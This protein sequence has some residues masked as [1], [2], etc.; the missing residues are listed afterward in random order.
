MRFGIG[1]S[2]ER[3]EDKRFLTGTGRYSDDINLAHQSHAAIVHSPHSHARIVSI[4]S[5]QALDAPGVIAVFT[6]ADISDAE[7]GDLPTIMQT[8]RADGTPLSAP[9]RAMLVKDTVRFAGDYVAMV[10]AQT[11]AQAKDAADLV[12]VEYEVLPAVTAT[13]AA[14]ADDAPLVWPANPNNISFERRLGNFDAVRSALET[15]AHVTRIDLPVSR[16]AQ[17]PMEPRCALGIYDRGEDRYTLYTGVQNPHDMR[18]EI[19]HEVLHIPET[20]LRVVSPDMGGGF[21]MRSTVFP[22]MALVLW[23]AR[24]LGRPVKW[25][26]DRSAAFLVDDQARDAMIRVELGLNAAAE[27]LAIRVRKTANVGAYL[28]WY[29]GYPA[30]GNLGSLAGPYRTPVICAHV[31]GVYTHTTPVAPYRGAGRPE[32]AL[33]IEQAVDQAARELGIDRVEI[34]R[35]N[36]I[37]ASAMPFQTGLTYLYDSGEFEANIDRVVETVDYE[38]FET[39]RAAS[40]A[41]GK[42]R[43]LGVVY[44]VEQSAGPSDEGADIRFDANGDATVTTGLHSHGQG[45]ETVFRQ[46]L[47]DALGLDFEQVRYVQGDTDL[48]P[49]GGGTGGSRSAGVGSGALLRASDQIIEKGRHI[50]AHLMEAASED[51]EFSDG[52]FEIAGTDRSVGITEVARTAFDASARPPDMDGGLSAF[53]TFRHKAPTF[54]NGCHASEVEIDPDTGKTEIL[55][56]VVCKDVGTV[57]N[58]RLLRGQLQGGIVQGFG[59][60]MTEQVVWG[61]DGQPITGSFMDYCLPKADNVPFCEIETNEVP[62][63]T[64]PLGIKGAGE[65]GTVGGLSCVAA[66][67]DDALTS[68][69]AGRIAMPA[70]PERVWRTLQDVPRDDE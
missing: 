55:R 18:R 19:A 69:G 10:I 25:L 32:A 1:Q 51:I 66:A 37:P 59:Q 2:A 53:A 26:G 62:T 28:S 40:T 43:G 36:L 65:A 16:I 47:C 21:G 14:A 35:R 42:I 41:S 63:P 12:A 45:H 64:N 48:I 70:T 6:G 34:R 30:F 7:L 49:V 29:G 60:I 5:R 11:A 17:V 22:E 39:R 24:Q 44:T 15:A 58:P 38:G 57:M 67:M 13:S 4:D 50:A 46:L 61:E 56:Y 9:A 3:P 20:R 23:A 31:T 54:P 52:R 8:T 33:A 27:F 68:V